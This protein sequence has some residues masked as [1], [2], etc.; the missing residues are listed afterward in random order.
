MTSNLIEAATKELAQWQSTFSPRRFLRN[1]H[2]Q[3]LAG[4]FLPRKAV[5]PIPENELV[6]VEPAHDG[7]A[8]QQGAVPDPLAARSRAADDPASPWA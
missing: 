6:E 5:L 8:P 7:L 2:L 3:T 4:N 1:A